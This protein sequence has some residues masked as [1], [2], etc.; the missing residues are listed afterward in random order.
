MSSILDP[1][2]RPILALTLQPRDSEEG[3]RLKHALSEIIEQDP[4]LKIDAESADQQFLVG[5]MSES[6][7]D[8]TCDT[9]A[10]RYA[11]KF[12]V[13]EPR[14]RYLETIR[15]TGEAEGKYIRQTGGL[16]NY[17]HCRLRL[18][19]NQ[20]GKGFEFINEIK[21]GVVPIEYIDPIKQ[22]VQSAMEAGIL[23][24]FPMVDMRV[25]LF[26]GSYHEADSN[27]MAFKIAGSIAFREAAKK[28][29][30]VL[31][32][33]VMDVEAGIPEEVVGA[34]I[35]DI[36]SRRGRIKDIT[37]SNAWCEM[38][39]IV[40]LSE[41]LSNSA[42]GRLKYPMQF[43]GYEPVPRGGWLEGDELGVT[44]RKPHSPTR[45]RGSAAA[46]LDSDSD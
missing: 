28:A 25:M 12:D 32:E 2:V 46:S 27:E 45:G 5:G 29:S 17:G 22:G 39:A 3:R 34:F 23:G 21:G 4:A 13:S 41:A 10:D 11:I 44:A 37:C 6:H 20:P 24:D 14:V 9:L 42:Q 43:L 1:R 16:G 35:N 8:Q 36:N 31:L 18:E 40:P 26:D 30:P 33:P 15:G 7:L 19:P 38:R